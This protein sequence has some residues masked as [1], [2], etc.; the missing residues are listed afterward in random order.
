MTSVKE[1][2]VFLTKMLCTGCNGHFLNEQDRAVVGQAV[3]G[4]SFRKIMGKKMRR[5]ASSPAFCKIC[6]RYSHQ[7]RMCQNNSLEGKETFGSLF[8]AFCEPKISICRQ[9][10]DDPQPAQAADCPTCRGPILPWQG[11][12]HV[13]VVGGLRTWRNSAQDTTL[14]NYVNKKSRIIFSVKRA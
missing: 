4:N 1:V 13:V 6:W 11:I 9:C 3:R 12:S 10:E 2:S 8:T 5:N 7:R 14:G